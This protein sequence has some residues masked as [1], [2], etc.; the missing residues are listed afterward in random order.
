M[1][2]SS[3]G[4]GKLAFYDWSHNH[5]V[6]ALASDPCWS[7]SHG[8]AQNRTFGI[9]SFPWAPIPTYQPPHIILP[10]WS[11]PLHSPTVVVKFRYLNRWCL[12]G[13]TFKNHRSEIPQITTR[14]ECFRHSDKDNQVQNLSFTFVQDQAG[15]WNGDGAA[16]RKD[17]LKDFRKSCSCRPGS[18]EDRGLGAGQT[19]DF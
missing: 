11:S 8:M 6:L 15:G 10:Y 4:M 1:G 16:V 2:M 12:R 13:S 7:E 9:H 3:A 5:K 19:V 18:Q 14:V 17:I